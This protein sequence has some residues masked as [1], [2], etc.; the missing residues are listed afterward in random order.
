V[1]YQPDE[2]TVLFCDFDGFVEPEIIK[3]R[4]VVVLK[5]HSTNSKLV[6][7][8]PLS[9]TAPT[10]VMPYHFEFVSNPVP[11]ARM[12]DITWAKCDMVVTISLERLDRFKIKS[13][14]KREYVEGHI[15]REDLASIRECVA[16]ALGLTENI[17][18][19]KKPVDS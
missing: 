14:G 5:K 6:T 15:S 7:I 3:S 17:A 1:L 8:V 2:G 19:E 4:P 11:T 12:G 16:I 9:T 13:Y 10:H 18:D